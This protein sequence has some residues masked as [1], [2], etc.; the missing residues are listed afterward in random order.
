MIVSNYF[1]KRGG[2]CTFSDVAG[3]DDGAIEVRDEDRGEL[4]ARGTLLQGHSHQHVHH[5]LLDVL[6]TAI[7]KRLLQS[8]EK[9]ESIHT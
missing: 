4:A 1:Q 3:V 2:V 9:G 5:L 8:K 7:C 6:D